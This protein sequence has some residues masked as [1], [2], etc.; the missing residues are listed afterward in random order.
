MAPTPSPCGSTLASAF[1]VTLSLKSVSISFLPPAFP[2]FCLLSHGLH[3]YGHRLIFI[4]TAAQLLE[5]AASYSSCF[6]QLRKPDKY[7]LQYKSQQNALM[8]SS[9]PLDL[10]LG[11]WACSG[12]PP[13]TTFAEARPPT[14]RLPSRLSHLFIPFKGID[15][16]FELRGESRLNQFV[17]TNWRRGNFFYFSLKGFRHKISKKPKDAA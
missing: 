8:A 1:L 9:C 4:P 12:Q 10:H 7:D 15:R 11:L 3:G 16:S 6:S 14:S 13:G 2:T 5:A 17:R